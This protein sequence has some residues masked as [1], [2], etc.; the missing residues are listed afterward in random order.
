MTSTSDRRPQLSLHYLA[1]HAPAHTC[2]QVFNV[3]GGTV[4]LLEGW[5]T[6]STIRSHQRWAV[7]DL[8][9]ESSTLLGE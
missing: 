4:E 5:R 8:A 2:G 7:K 1:S 3:I 9:V 6:V